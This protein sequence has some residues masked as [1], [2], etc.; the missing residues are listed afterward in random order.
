MKAKY[1][2]SILVMLLA[3]CGDAVV[4]E[5]VTDLDYAIDSY[6]YALRWS[7]SNDA[8][9]YHMNRDGT[10]PVID[11]SA[12]SQIRVTGFSI[13]EKTLDS[14]HNCASV[15]GVLNYYHNNGATLRTVEYTQT[16]WFEP[17]S[18]KWYIDSAFPQFK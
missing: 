15:K 11:A 2:L 6:A 7:R 8:V 9:A 10:R 1:G 12:M 18:G 3:G 16:W 4:R 14:D 5:R 17:E 13:S